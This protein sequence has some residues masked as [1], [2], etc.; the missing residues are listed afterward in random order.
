MNNPNLLRFAADIGANHNRSMKRVESLIMAAKSIGCWAVKFQY[1]QAETL[2]APGYIP[3][4]LEEKEMPL[5]FIPNIR[6]ICNNVG[7]VFGCSV[8]H[9]EDV[10]K[11]APHVDYLKVS[12]YE[13]NK[14]SL[15]KR[16]AD[17]GLP[18]HISTGM[19]LTHEVN[20][21]LDAAQN[22]KDVV[23]YHCCA[24]YPAKEKHIHLRKLREYEQ[25]EKE[26]DYDLGYSDHSVS[27]PVICGAVALGADYIEFHLD[28][29][30]NGWEFQSGHCYLPKYAKQMIGSATV[31]K[32]AMKFY[33]I[34]EVNRKQRSDPIDGLR[35]FQEIR[36]V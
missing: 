19:A 10:K 4:G 6:K 14:V 25:Y 5:S 30:G 12:S 33:S 17:T 35:P 11:I 21:A 3:W 7:I 29:D 34:P 23:L 36:N 18:V 2:Y 9:D 20:N 1:F 16:M 32:Q 22:C 27:I 8:F 24:E 28:D 13:I 15:I 31:T 26:M